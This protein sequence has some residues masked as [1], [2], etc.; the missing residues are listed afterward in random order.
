MSFKNIFKKI[1]SMDKNEDNKNVQESEVKSSTDKLVEM[2]DEIGDDEIM[3]SPNKNILFVCNSNTDISPMAEA[4]F[5]QKV[6][7]Q[8]AFSAGLYVQTGD[9]ASPETI[10]VCANH[11]IDLTKH[12][13]QNINDIPI[14]KWIWF[15]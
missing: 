14:K 7:N 5:N 15:L 10:Q 4:I 2:D 12:K 9:E 1:L 11:G 8:K 13:T 6:P 3:F